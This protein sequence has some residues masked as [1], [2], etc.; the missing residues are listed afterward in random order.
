MASHMALDFLLLEIASL[1]PW[2][3]KFNFYQYIV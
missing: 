3:V 1:N 2:L